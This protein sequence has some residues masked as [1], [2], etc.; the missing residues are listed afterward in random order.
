MIFWHYLVTIILTNLLI[1]NITFANDSLEGKIQIS[2]PNPNPVIAGQK[3]VFQSIILNQGKEK[4]LKN[5]YYIETEIFDN[6]KN[7]IIYL[8][9]L[10]GENDINP[11]ETVIT[12]IEF[13]VPEEYSGIYNYK[14]YVIYK[15]KRIIE[16][17]FYS[18]NV[19][20]NIKRTVESTTN[21]SGNM[22]ISYRTISDKN[23]QRY[24]GNINMNII[25]Q[26]FNKPSLFNIYTFHNPVSDNNNKTE[27][28]I[29][30][31]LFKNYSQTY[32]LSI[33]DIFPEFSYLSLYGGGMRGIYYQ[34]KIDNFQFDVVGGYLKE[35]VEGDTNL[36]S[37]YKRDLIASSINYNFS[38]LKLGL[39]YVKSY[40]IENSVK[41]TQT[42]IK[43]EK[44]DVYGTEIDFKL[45]PN[46][47]LIA[48]YFISKNVT[49]I[50]SNK[51]ITDYA[52]RTKLDYNIKKNNIK[53]I[54]QEIRP[55]FRSLGSPE[56]QN[57]SREFNFISNFSI[58][59]NIKFNLKYNR[60]N[61]NLNNDETKNTSIQQLYGTDFIF[62][63]YKFYSSVLTAGF[64][65]TDNMI[66]V[67]NNYNNFN[68][69]FNLCLNSQI[70]KI[71]VML[72]FQFNIFKDKIN[73][74]NDCS[75]EIYK[76]FL[77]IPKENISF[78]LGTN[79]TNTVDSTKVNINLSQN[80]NVNITYNIIPEF[81]IG[82]LWSDFGFQEYFDKSLNNK[83]N[84][85]EYNFNIEL[86]I[87]F[88]PNMSLFIGGLYNSVNYSNN[89]LNI[90]KQGI[91]TKIIYSF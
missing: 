78:T 77:N 59:D 51:T 62:Y 63:M 68:Q 20:E 29:F 48:E 28:K 64:T 37:I 5:E 31:L 86:E 23:E 15:N 27:N 60:W 47:D 35:L 10:K 22:T 43:P 21:I 50:F 69:I 82:Q 91:N 56:L 1:C 81:L 88:K 18:F 61:N 83:N 2:I 90:N 6:E 53:I 73:I 57:D 84:K 40:D 32:N 49:D 72:Y 33:G 14:I 89:S 26:M 87:K 7:H 71:N 70:N 65:Y 8:D 30:N 46:C 55:S 74:S 34:K 42:S 3:I 9:K 75:T 80:Y 85:N 76:L 17:D 13:K 41:Q 16:S 66:D 52:Y 54:Y 24:I 11:G 4:W 58:I 25:G 12:Y 44:T 67:R 79:F 39:N 45:K 38:N 19:A 36:S